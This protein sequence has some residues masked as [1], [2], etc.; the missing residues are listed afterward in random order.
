M[1]RL[2]TLLFS[3]V[4]SGSFY[5]LCNAQGM[6]GYEGGVKIFLNRDSTSYIRML[7]WSQ[8]QMRYQTQN[9]GTSSVNNPNEESAFDIAIRRSRMLFHGQIGERLLLFWILG[10]NNQTFSSGGFGLAAGADNFTDGKRQ[11]VFVH[12]AW[13]EFKWSRELY[14]GVGILTW[15]GL[16]RQ[17][18]WATLNFLSFDSPAYG[19]VTL[20]ATDQFARMFG[21]YAKGS[22]GKFN[23]RAVLTKPFAIPNPGIAGATGA[24][25]PNWAAG[26]TTLP[27][28]YN[29]AQ[30]AGDNNRLLYQAYANYDFFEQESSVLPFMVGSYLGTKKVFNIGAGFMYHPRA[31]WH[32]ARPNRSSTD[33]LG[34]LFA[35]NAGARNSF[36]NLSGADRTAIINGL[37]DGIFPVPF[38]GN[39]PSPVLGPGPAPLNSNPEGSPL[40]SN[41]FY[42]AYGRWNA[43][44]PVAVAAVRD[45][46]ID[47]AYTNQFH[48]AVD[49]FL[50]LP[51]RYNSDGSPDPKGWSMTSHGSYFRLNFG[52]NYVRNIG[53]LPIGQ[54]NPGPAALYQ[55]PEFSGPAN[56][57]PVHGTGNIFYMQTGVL[58][59]YELTEG[60][61]RFQPYVCLSYVNFERLAEP[62]F[63]P[64]F[65]LNWILS[66][67]NAKITLHWRPRPVYGRAISVTPGRELMG[68]MQRIG[69]EHEV[70]TQFHMYL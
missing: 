68:G 48:F 8:I 46:F 17:T 45:A 2:R 52:P 50:E 55:Q 24:I 21:M 60:W 26:L 12:D 37:N 31:H 41:P 40:N 34:D 28:A 6:E 33:I 61:G 47:T 57:F 63:M 67:Q 10:I 39:P 53:F 16:S 35:R 43:A 51:F 66:G 27:N 5:H 29:I 15:S 7:M 36:N 18:N 32:N 11:S 22:I 62:Y 38:S 58:T 25:P 65:G 70:I 30:W 1:K 69:T 44:D 4:L 9:P 59:P 64:E 14:I 13:T 23:Y 42:A 3:L 49:Y 54:A 19:W 20:D 56:A